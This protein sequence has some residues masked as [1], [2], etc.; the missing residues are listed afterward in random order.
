MNRKFF[1]LL[2]LA[3]LSALCACSGLDSNTDDLAEPAVFV[4]TDAVACGSAGSTPI[5]L[6]VM[7][8]RVTQNGPVV[9]PQGPQRVSVDGVVTGLAA[10]QSV[11]GLFIDDD[12]DCP[13]VN[14]AEL[15]AVAG[16]GSF[17]LS[18]DAATSNGVF[19]NDFRVVAV[20]GP[21]GATPSCSA[22]G[23]CVQLTVGGTGQS[24]SGLSNAVGVRL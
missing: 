19:I 14:W 3:G 4:A 10:G 18:L 2:A 21:S 12:V 22:A 6:E 7:G 13:I 5:V 24:V 8:V 1:T 16:D 20:T 11:Y 9:D 17:T 15:T 23:D